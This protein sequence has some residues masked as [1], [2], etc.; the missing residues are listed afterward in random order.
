MRVVTVEQMRAIEREADERYG[1]NGPALMAV[2]GKSAATIAREWVGGPIAGSRWVVLVGPGN[3]GGDGRVMA[4][5][6]AAHGASVALYIWSTGAVEWLGGANG[7]RG[8]LGDEDHAL[9]ALTRLVAG[10]DVVVDALLGIGHARALG[11]D[12]RAVIRVVR[13]ERLR[14]DN[15]PRAVALD[16]PTGLDADTGA[17]DAGSFVA[18]LTITLGFPKLGLYWYP[19]PAYVGEVRVGSIGLPADMPV[20]GVAELITPE[21]ISA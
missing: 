4:G 2:A 7:W 15:H 5:H 14:R 3:N 13:D 19:G 12:M 10:A 17:T 18:D 8:D 1:L 6:L 9:A 16:I 21:L 20:A 11:D